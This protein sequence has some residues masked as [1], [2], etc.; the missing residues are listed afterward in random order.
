VLLTILESLSQRGPTVYGDTPPVFGWHA[1]AAGETDGAFLRTPPHPVL[2]AKLPDGEAPALVELLRS[3]D[4]SLAQANVTGSDE[5]DFIAGWAADT[6][7]AAI[8]GAATAR[9]ERTRL[10]LL[11]ELTPIDPS[12]PGT[13]RVATD[14]HWDLLVSWHAA[15]AEETGALAIDPERMVRDRMSYGGI[16]LWEADGTP[17]ALAALSRP[18]AG[19]TRV[20]TVYT[21]QQFRRRGFG[22]AITTAV[23]QSAIEAG[24]SKVV[25]FTDVRNPTSNALYQRLGYRPIEDRVLLDFRPRPSP[26]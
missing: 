13:A 10:F 4:A 24:A 8:G 15:F 11:A 16:M 23:T 5:A 17:V 12:P 7:S 22:G 9:R 1:D 25:L 19:V 3:T 14:A 6:G 21:P 2:L 20:V 26:R 18:V